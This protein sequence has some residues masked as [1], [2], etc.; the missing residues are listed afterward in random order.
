MNDEGCR[1]GDWQTHVVAVDMYTASGGGDSHLV[2]RRDKSIVLE[3]SRVQP[4]AMTADLPDPSTWIGGEQ[5]S[6]MI[7]PV[8][9]LDPAASADDAILTHLS[10]HGPATPETLARETGVSGVVLEKRLEQLAYRQQIIMSGF[11]PTDALHVLD[12]LH[13][14]NREKS[15]AAAQILASQV[16]LAVEKFCRLVV[17]QTEK[18]IENSILEYVSRKIWAMEEAT[19]LI[20]RRDNELFSIQFSLKLPIIG[21]GAAARSFLPA[22]AERLQTTAFFPE[23]YEVG[24]AIGAIRIAA[25]S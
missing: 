14:G 7:F 15:L 20:S 18:T 24:N 3:K 25:E 1:I 21:I 2:C 12:R 16:G 22:V 9:G 13:I 17:R 11:T 5:Q 19:P 4:L 10:T 8:P 23:H 6:A